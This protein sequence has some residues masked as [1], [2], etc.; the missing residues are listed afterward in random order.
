VGIKKRMRVSKYEL[1]KTTKTFPVLNP[2][3][4]EKVGDA[5]QADSTMIQKV[6]TNAFEYKPN[7]SAS[8][9]SKMLDN[10][11]DA[12]EAQGKVCA[13][14]ITSE[15][16]L[17]MKDS[18]LEVKRV[19]SCARNASQVAFRM[20]KNMT[21]EFVSGT[22]EGLPELQVITEPL[23]LVVGITPF[24]HP[25][26]QMAHKVFPAIAV[27]ACMVAKPSEKTPLSALKLGQIVHECGVPHNMIAIVTGSPAENIVKALVTSPLVDMVT[28]TGSYSV[29]M[30]IQRMIVQSCYPTKRFVPELGGCSSFII[31]DDADNDKSVEAVLYGCFKNSGQRC[32]S[33]RRVIVTPGIA[34]KFVTKL[35]ERIS[36]LKCGEPQNPTVD[37]GTMI[38]AEQAEMVQKRVD[39]AIEDGAELKY[40]NK[41]KGAQLNQTLLD[42]VPLSTELVREETFGPVCPV[43][44]AKDIDDAIRIAKDTQYALA[45]AVMTQDESLARRVSD[46][47][48]VGQF[49]WNG[50]PGYRTE[51]A[52]FGGFKKSGNGEK[53]GIVMAAYGMRRMRTFYRHPQ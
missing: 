40:G 37:I 29:G 8:E 10:I 19:V 30:S 45:G 34:E 18:T 4:G 7:F 23:D 31:A 48:C 3:T 24:N 1:S 12:I 36:H 47:L 2:Y 25:M 17:S 35:A 14:L 16:G 27:G 13:E 51:N 53:E 38:S 9:R 41:R 20:D 5:P 15:S 52:P 39:R 42:H 11:A 33:V 28:F 43:I 6:L 49:S 32:T 46:M 44:R 21:D 22:K 26:N 50:I